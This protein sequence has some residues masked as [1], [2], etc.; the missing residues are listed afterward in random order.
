VLPNGRLFAHLT[1]VGETAV[2][3]G[4]TLGFLTVLAASIGL[5]LVGVYGLA[6]FWQGASQQGFHLLLATSL[7]VFIGV[8]AGRHWGIDRWILERRARVL[9]A[10]LLV[11][12]AILLG[13]A[14]APPPRAHAQSAVTRPLVLLDDFAFEGGAANSIQ[15]GD[16]AMAGVATGVVRSALRDAETVRAAD[17]TR[18]AD[19]MRGLDQLGLKCSA[20]VDCI[21]GVGQRLGATYVVAG[22]VSKISNLIWYLSGQLI[23]VKTGRVVESDGFELKGER[24]DMV[25]RGAASLARRLIR[26]ASAAPRAASPE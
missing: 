5:M 22:K 26:A 13:S 16:S 25:P 18:A 14:L 9:P 15:P 7:L 24:D 21:R 12:L 3:L 20:S 2:G 1:A 17:S 10:K 8:R 6:T 23:D 11:C 4:L 19:E